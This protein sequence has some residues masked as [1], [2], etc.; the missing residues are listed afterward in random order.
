MNLLGYIARAALVLTGASAGFAVVSLASMGYREMAFLFLVTI[1]I[2]L[3]M[4]VY[5]Y[6][7][8]WKK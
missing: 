8:G 7:T 3:S 5:E 2:P 1:T 6:M 4:V